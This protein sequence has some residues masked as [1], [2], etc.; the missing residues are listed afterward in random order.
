MVPL[1]TQMRN[2]QAYTQLIYQDPRITEIVPKDKTKIDRK[3][4]AAGSLTEDD[5]ILEY[6]NSSQS[7]GHSSKQEDY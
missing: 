7:P 1:K 6:Q 3:N 2:S 4:S 5:I